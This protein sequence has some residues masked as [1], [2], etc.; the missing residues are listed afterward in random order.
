LILEED[1]MPYNHDPEPDLPRVPSLTA[2]DEPVYSAGTF[3]T[4]ATAL[5]AA[6]AAFG[7]P[8]S[9]DQQA[10]VLAAMAVLAPVILALIAR[11]RAWSPQTVR[12]LVEQERTKA[13]EAYRRQQSGG[14]L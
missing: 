12:R 14:V 3:V 8:I 6:G 5:L 4:V 7:L 13:V 1:P 2:P 11:A 9:D 10:A